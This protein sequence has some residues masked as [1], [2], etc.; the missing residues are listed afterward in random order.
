M[1][2]HWYYD[3][4]ALRKD[5]GTVRD[6]KPPKNPHPDSILWRSRYE[7]VNEKADILHDQA[8]YW[9]QRGIH[10]H[11]FLEAG[12]N[13]LNLKLV[14][15][16]IVSLL[17]RGSYDA[18]DYL[19]RYI[20]FMTTPGTHRDT[21]VEE[22]HRHFFGQYARGVPP[23]KC[24]IREKHIGGLV[25]LPAIVVFYRN[26]PAKARQAALEHLSLTHLGGKM[27]ASAE[28][29][30]QLLLQTLEGNGLKTTLMETMATGKHPFAGF[31]F[32]KWLGE[33]DER[34]VGARFSTACY[35][36]DSIPAVLYLALKYHDQPEKGLIANT[37][38]GGDNAYRG[39]VLGA[40]LGAEN[41]LSAFPHRWGTGLLDPPPELPC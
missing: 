41:G 25:G 27:T 34:V 4:E 38:L 36:E 28:L 23:R 14:R 6:Y 39:A 7:P 5:Y 40:L 19:A 3:R 13:T 37:N 10:Y 12:E 8:R 2:V 9:G 22:Y 17:D 16:L 20:A 1:P 35:V 21:Y 32:V 11:Q 33:P 29:L 26:D 15:V 30:I 31:P 24:G 18:D